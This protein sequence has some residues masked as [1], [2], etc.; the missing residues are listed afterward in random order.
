M[1]TNCDITKLTTLVS[2]GS[3]YCETFTVCND[4]KEVLTNVEAI[5]QYPADGMIPNSNGST[6]VGA[7]DPTTSVWTIPILHPGKSEEITVCFTV[8]DSCELKN[9]LIKVVINGNCDCDKGGCKKIIGLLCCDFAECVGSDSLTDNGD[10]TITHIDVA[11]NEVTFDVKITEFVDNGDGTWTLTDDFGNTVTL[12]VNPSVVTQIVATGNPIASHEDGL[13]NTVIIN[14]TVTTVT[15][16]PITG[17]ITFTS[18]DGTV[19]VLTINEIDMDITSFTING[20]EITF[21]SEDGTTAILDIC[22]VVAL[23]CNATISN[24]QPDGSFDFTDNAGNTIT[25]PGASSTVT[26]SFG[27]EDGNVTNGTANTIATHVAGDGTSTSINETVTFLNVELVGTNLEVGYINEAGDTDSFVIDLSQF[28]DDTNTTYTFGESN[29]VITITDSD[30]NDTT[31]DICAI[32]AANCPPQA[33]ITSTL[34]E[35]TPGV[36]VYTDETGTIT[37]ITLPENIV[38]NLVDN[39][40]GTITYTNEAGNPTLIDICSIVDTHCNL[41]GGT[42]TEVT[43]GV[44]VF[45]NGVDPPV[46]IDICQEVADNCNLGLSEVTDLNQNT[47]LDVNV[48]PIATHDDGNGNIVSIN[49]TITGFADDP[50]D[51]NSQIFTSENGTTTCV[52][53]CFNGSPITEPLIDNMTS[54][55]YR[56]TVKD[57]VTGTC[58][59]P[60]IRLLNQPSGAHVVMGAN[61]EFVLTITDPTLCADGEAFLFNYEVICENGAT[62]SALVSLVMQL[63]PPPTANPD[64][65]VGFV[66]QPIIGS[67][68]GNDTP[69]D[70]SCDTTFELVAAPTLGTVSLGDNGSYVYITSLTTTTPS[71]DQFTYEILCCGVK[72]GVIT[73][74]DIT[75]LDAAPS[76]DF[77]VLPSNDGTLTPISLNAVDDE[78]TGACTTVTYEWLFP[79]ASNAP[80]YT[81]TVDSAFGIIDGS[82]DNFTYLPNQ[83]FCGVSYVQYKTFCDGVDIGNATHTLH[84]TCAS[85]VDDNSFGPENTPYTGNVSTNDFPCINGGSTTYELV[86]AVVGGTLCSDT[87]G[88]SVVLT[89]FDVN[90]G[91]YTLTPSGGYGN[92]HSNP[93]TNNCCSFE[94]RIRCTTPNGDFVTT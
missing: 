82:P 27:N 47:Q 83:G 65:N 23:N 93:S 73:T 31:F 9:Q 21:T 15:Q 34:I 79:E 51:L 57:K 3:N 86:G 38:T 60:V 16:D 26:Q 30:G 44:F 20:S 2:N 54:C 52:P 22:N 11:G 41:K 89:A 39:A 12:A 25:V 77:D 87:N 48:Q 45:D 36:F 14:E 71:V 37:T 69:C 59:Q 28:V 90:T 24:L 80:T 85:V 42:L 81:G 64:I 66:G 18:E 13:G 84:T 92:P 63:P 8:L 19:T 74:V 50:N 76:D 78:D 88:G 94:Y 32:V 56:G 4:T 49:E 58:L 1:S 67:V 75:I 40:N 68:I 46:T 70:P 53:K 6:S 33:Q 10:G 62:S 7:F 29:G 91:E 43:D 55:E 5:I 72:T 17:D 35:V 61:G